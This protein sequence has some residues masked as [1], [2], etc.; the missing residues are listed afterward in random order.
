MLSGFLLGLSTG[1]FCLSWCAPVFVPL[2]LGEKKSIK[3]SFKVFLKFN[4][5]RLLACLLFGALVGWLGIRIESK[6]I[7]DLSWVGLIILA[8]LMILYGLGL[9]KSRIKFCHRSRIFKSPEIFG[10]FVGF[11]ICPPFLLALSY[12]FNLRS[13][14]A[15][16][17][18][19]L[20]F[21]LGTIIYFI[22][23]T[24]LGLFSKIE[25]VR[26]IA[27]VSAFLVGIIFL[28]YGI[29]ELL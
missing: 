8:T 3:E 20:S 21:F 13:I 17:L 18:F 4:L 5:G 16:M 14:L 2:V 25:K 22:L 26:H 1:V 29:K 12:T 19:F 11:N 7:H 6:F 9:T 10:F 15:G 27:R 28:I 24:F 23:P